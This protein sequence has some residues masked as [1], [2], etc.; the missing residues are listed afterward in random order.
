MRLLA[1]DEIGASRGDRA[2][3][4]DEPLYRDALRRVVESRENEIVLALDADTINVVG[5]LQLTVTP[6]MSRRGSTRLTVESVRVTTNRRAS[7]IGSALMRWVMDV[8]APDLHCS[9]VQ[10]TSATER[11]GAHRFYER[12]GFSVSHVGFKYQVPLPTD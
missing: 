1:E 2:R 12:L 8:A 4:V 7:G 9:L 11:D 6:G 5:A 10:L 3:A